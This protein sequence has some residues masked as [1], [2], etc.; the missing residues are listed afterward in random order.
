MQDTLQRFLLEH[1]NIRGEIIRLDK[2]LQTACARHPYP[3]IIQRL[4]GEV[5]AATALVGATLK[6]EGNLTLQVQGEGPVKLLVAQV[7]DKQQLRGLAQWQDG[8]P[9]ET[10]P[11]I[12]GDGHLLITIKPKSGEHYQGIVILE[13][14]NLAD[15][16]ESYFQR[17]EQLPTCIVLAVHE[18]QAVGLLLQLMPQ[19]TPHIDQIFWQ[20]LIAAVKKIPAQELFAKS[21]QEI[22]QQLL[23]QEDI[24]LFDA[25]PVCFHCDCSVERMERAVRLF[26]QK[27]AMEILSTSKNLTVTCEFCNNQYDFTKSDVERIFT[28]N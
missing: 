22:L 18:Q 12:F 8:A 20:E 21:N 24:L 27:E 14:R 26:G 5:L 2:T 13:G 16:L 28:D 11:D 19:Q 10:V 23:P 15:S 3:P 17:S 7:N 9:L 4:L 1:R 6:I 25:T